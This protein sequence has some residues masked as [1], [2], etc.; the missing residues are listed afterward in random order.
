MEISY[1][2]YDNEIIQIIENEEKSKDNK[3]EQEDMKPILKKTEINK[4]FLKKQ[5]EEY[6][7]LIDKASDLNIKVTD[8]KK[9]LK[10]Y[11]Y[12]ENVLKDI[13][14]DLG[15]QTYTLENMLYQLQSTYFNDIANSL[16]KQYN[17][18]FNKEID[19]LFLQCIND[20]IPINQWNN[21]LKPLL[22]N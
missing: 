16:K 5:K 17:S 12:E 20:K 22:I 8:M 15:Q 4:E 3:E 7:T 21:W 9:E 11:Q 6:D 14:E 10:Q 13:V 1:L 18:H 2:P 19:Q